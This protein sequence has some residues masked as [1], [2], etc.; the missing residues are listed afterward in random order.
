MGD[1]CECTGGKV[2]N[3]EGTSCVEEITDPAAIVLTYGK[4]NVDNTA[5][6]TNLLKIKSGDNYYCKACPLGEYVYKGKA[7]DV[8]L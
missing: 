4:Q 8:C 2:W 5:T 3:V 7:A 1:H 6:C